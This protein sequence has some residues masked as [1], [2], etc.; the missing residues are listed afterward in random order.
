MGLTKGILLGTGAALVSVAAAQAADLPVRKAAPVEYVRVCDAYG[1]GFFY[2][3]GTDT[4]IRIGGRVRADYAVVGTGDIYSRLGTQNTQG[5]AARVAVGASGFVVPAD[6]TGIYYPAG[7]FG[8]AG[9]NNPGQLIGVSGTAYATGAAINQF[10]NYFI[11]NQGE[12][13]NRRPVV[14]LPADAQNLTGWEARARISFDVRTNTAWGV[15]QAVGQL[16][17]NRTS[18]VLR[19]SGTE[20]EGIGSGMTLEAAYVRFAGFT[21]GAARDN[22]ANMP[23]VMYMAAGHWASFANGAKQLAY[24][25]TAGGGL[26]ATVAIQDYL[27]TASGARVMGQVNSVYLGQGVCDPGDP[28]YGNNLPGNLFPSSPGV[29]RYRYDAAPQFNARVDWQQGWG[30][31]GLSAAVARP[32]FNNLADSYDQSETV[33]AVGGTLRF[34]L[35]M[36]AAGSRIDFVAAYA[37]GMTEYTTNWNSFKSSDATRGANGFVLLPTSIVLTPTG[38]ETVKSWSV[39]ALFQHYWTPQWRTALAA[40]YGQVDGTNSSKACLWNGGSCFGDAN[41][42]YLA[43]QLA[44]LPTRDFEIGVELAYTRVSQDVRGYVGNFSSAGTVTDPI[45]ATT[46]V[47]SRSDD[48]FTGRLR[49]ERNF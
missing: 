28:C 49:V 45:Y 36:L 20:S 38:P 39:G 10:S 17:M 19:S 15:V 18:G 34:N 14:L 42:S 31:L 44:W 1:A 16:R 5:G 25:F 47:V 24:T 3:P 35:P 12:A 11:V 37:D 9:S 27:D 48:N 33:W 30:A 7:S 41:V 22:F 46:G 13:G 23:S 6:G 29:I 8:T 43:A 4:C 21:F 32:T 26:S 40:S 2:I